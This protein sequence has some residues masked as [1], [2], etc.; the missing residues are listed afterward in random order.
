MSVVVKYIRKLPKHRCRVRSCGRD[1]GIYGIFI[2]VNRMDKHNVFI[3]APHD[4]NLRIVRYFVIIVIAVR[5][6]GNLRHIYSPALG[7]AVENGR[8]LL[9]CN[10]IIG[11]KCCIA[12]PRSTRRLLLPMQSVFCTN[13]A[14]NPKISNF[15]LPPGFP[16]DGKTLSRTV[17][18]LWSCPGRR[19]RS[20]FLS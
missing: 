10:N 1:L 11:R 9:S 18:A 12:V 19:C 13:P 4:G 3:K 17:R 6:G 15:R 14:L 5:P 7:I 20:P 16:Q 2:P 8:N